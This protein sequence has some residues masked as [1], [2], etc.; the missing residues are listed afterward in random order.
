MSRM[1]AMPGQ[2]DPNSIKIRQKFGENADENCFI[3]IES[4][5]ASVYSLDP[6]VLRAP[7]R[8]KARIARARQVAMY[9][10]HVIGEYSLTSIGEFFG[11]DRTTAAYACS[12]VEDMRD[13]ASFDGFVSQLEAAVKEWLVFARRVGASQ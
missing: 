6:T 10:S 8:C 13:D 11:R 9:L 2:L 1:D 4:I 7:T 12:L 3:A 5:V